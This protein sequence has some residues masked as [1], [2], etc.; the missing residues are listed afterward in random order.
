MTT[1]DTATTADGRYQAKRERA[2]TIRTDAI[3]PGDRLSVLGKVRTVVS[4]EPSG[5]VNRRN[6]PI[7]T[8]RYRPET[9]HERADL[10]TF[11]MLPGNTSH[12]AG[13]WHLA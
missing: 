2:A 13:L 5:Y 11:G 8:V 4:V 9:D 1:I 6:R 7:L 3:R 12:D 10:A